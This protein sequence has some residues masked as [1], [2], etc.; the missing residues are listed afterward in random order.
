MRGKHVERKE[1]Y[2]KSQDID[3]WSYMGSFNLWVNNL[4]L[5]CKT[6]IDLIPL[7]TSISQTFQK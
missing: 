3:F 4:S 7:F 2:P 6:Q 1:Y 5:I